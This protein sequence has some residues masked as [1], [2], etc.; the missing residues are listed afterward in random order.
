MVCSLSSPAFA[1]S[2]S[3][4]ADVSG[5]WNAAGSWTGGNI[6]GTGDTATFGFTLTAPRTV[7]VDANRN[8]TGITFSHTTNVGATTAYTLSG[9][10]L[11]LAN[12][13]LIQSTSASGTHTDTISSA[14]A[15]QGDGGAATFT[16]GATEATSLMNIGAVTGVSTGVNT[17]TLTLNGANTGNNIVSGIIGNG[18]AGGKVAVT[19]AGTGKWVLSGGNT[20]T[21]TT[22]LSEGTLRATTSAAALGAGSLSL[23]GGTLELANDIG[24]TFGRNTTVTGS[25]TIKSE[26]L[27]NGVGVTH[28][29]GT[30]SMG[31]QTLTIDKDA[32]VTSGTAGLTFGATTLTATGGTF[33]ANS[34]ALLTLGSV[35]GTATS[36]T[37]NGAGDTAIT[38]VIGTTTGALTKDGAGTLTL[39][40][41]NTY[42]GTTTI[43]AGTLNANSSAALGDHSATNTLI[44]NGGTLKAGGAI[45]SEATRLVTLTS[46]GIIDTNGNAVSIAG[47]ISGAG[48]LTKSGGIG[49]LTLSADNNYTGTTTISTGTLQVGNGS[50]T[51]TLSH[52]G[53]IINNAT[54]S[55]NR[56]NV[57]EMDNIISGTGAIIQ[58]GTGIGT[59][60]LTANNTY[61]GV[62]TITSGRLRVS[63]I[64][65]GGVAGNLGQAGA[66]AANLVFNGG[67]LQS[68]ATAGTAASTNRNF[69]INAGKTAT[70]DI[71]FTSTLTIS[72]ASTAST[73]GL[74][75]EGIGTLVLSG[76]N[77]YTGT[78]TISMGTLELSGG[79]AI[80]D[81]SA[82]V[83]ANAGAILKLNASER[84][85]SLSGGGTLG[86]D[87][88]L[89]ANTLTVGDTN[90]TS[91]G[92]IISG[93]LGKLTKV[94]SG[95]LTLSSSN[96]YSGLTTINAGTL[97]VTNDDAIVGAVTV[98][99]AVDAATFNIGTANITLA[100]AYTQSNNSTLNVTVNGVGTSGSISATSASVNA[101]SN[102]V[103]AVA[104]SS[105]IPTGTRFTIVDV[106]GASIGGIPTVTTTSARLRFTADTSGND[107]VLTTS[108]VA[109]YFSSLASNSNAAAVGTVLDNITNPSSDME[110]ILGTM[111]NLSDAQ[112][113]AALNT[114]V[115]E[116]D[117]GVINLTTSS[118]DAFVGASFERMGE[119]LRPTETGVSSGD[120]TKLNN[121][122][123][124]GYGSYLNQ[125]MR[126]GIDGYDGW[127]AGTALG[128]DRLFNNNTVLGISGGYAYGKVDSNINNAKTDINSGQGT[129]YAG[130]QDEVYPYYIDAAGTFAWNW[131][132]GKRNITIGSINRIANADYDGQQYGLYIGGGCKILLEDIL[133]L[134]PTA[135][136]RWSHLRLAGYTETGADS[137][138]LTVKAQN[139]DILQSG[140]G[141]KL[142]RPM[143]MGS[144]VFTPEV[145]GQWLYDF[146]GDNMVMTSAFTGGGA[147]FNSNG[148]KPAQSSFDVGGK[149]TF[150][151]SNG[152]NV[153][154]ACDSE[155]KDGFF[156]IYGS[157]ELMYNF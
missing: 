129:I 155:I 76:S 150:A 135:S 25:T 79:T 39:T 85:G 63:T 97:A 11:L 106:G 9:G 77:L 3:W 148:A 75:K 6:P 69:T 102:V 68:Y 100:G 137:M 51:G 17:T 108:R 90:S 54:L 95:T 88:N 112:V 10:N 134:T 67:T 40:G 98:G 66:D 93:A 71:A 12:G 140:L 50:T 87:V 82:I 117:A 118:L 55:L 119:V 18:T 110:Y 91:Y 30:L 73:G 34:G 128:A 120:E 15:I 38:G 32:T 22:T 4:L 53:D 122:W 59:T 2:D 74:T 8:I 96:T 136:L 157:M 94:G 105:Y 143:E 28:T 83:L 47:V 133:E 81:T 37:V 152:V 33:T 151:M 130:Y 99:N 7:T 116:I 24:L 45:T 52:S 84:I 101:G 141:A 62:T 138:D 132:G 72:G 5:S 44:F 16:A 142:A 42:S 58:A 109:L 92:G 1:I 153:I 48:G 113:A 14:I 27:T 107:L 80:A 29:L 124:K 154:G 131:Y 139:Y 145:H 149:L 65:D 20:Y 146:I 123:G 115:P 111:E 144:G 156:A 21:G 147:S 35:T 89:Q 127:N 64:G 104:T 19:K 121:V 41:G 125:K 46:T 56:S 36:F 43:T 126:K 60:T 23:G 70:I 86:G 26:R 78:T 57:M 103:V 114:M 13:G 49:T 31:A 61:T